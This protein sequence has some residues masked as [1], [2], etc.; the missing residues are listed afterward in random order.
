MCFLHSTFKSCRH[1][2][3]FHDIKSTSEFLVTLRQQHSLNSNR[4]R[5]CL[6]DVNKFISLLSLGRSQSRRRLT[7][8]LWN[9]KK[10]NRRTLYLGGDP[11][12]AT[13]ADSSGAGRFGFRKIESQKQHPER[14]KPIEENTS[15][16]KRPEPHFSSRTAVNPTVT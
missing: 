5:R 7:T 8:T 14:K 12:V 13:S 3:A 11:L 4:K 2:E 6:G 9:V 10:R 15:I 1:C 16:S